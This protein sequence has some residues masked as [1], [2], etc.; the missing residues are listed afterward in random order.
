MNR[1]NKI[2]YISDEIE[3]S[4][5]DRNYI[6]K[7]ILDEN[8]KYT[9]NKNGIFVNLS[10]LDDK[11]IDIMYEYM[12]EK[13]YDTFEQKRDKQI[14]NYKNIAETETDIKKDKDIKET[15]D[16]NIKKTFKKIDNL[17]DID[18]QIIELSKT[19]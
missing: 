4:N 10:I 15:I 14:K 7:Y 12:S 19:I 2:K 5:I 1:D 18:L 11:N 13:K 8:I 17:T 6:I 3:N 9:K 16:L